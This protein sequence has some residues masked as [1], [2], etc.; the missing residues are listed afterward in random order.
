MYVLESLAQNLDRGVPK[1]NIVAVAEKR[2]VGQ[3]PLNGLQALLAVAP[4]QRIETPD[5]V[6]AVYADESLS[7]VGDLYCGFLERLVF[8]S[9]VSCFEL[10][11]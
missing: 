4:H 10:W 2:R 1:P 8:R 9:R 3:L 5:D 6:L 11:G 7:F